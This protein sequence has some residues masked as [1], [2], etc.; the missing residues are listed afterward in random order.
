MVNTI[1]TTAKQLDVILVTPGGSG[2]QVTQIVDALRCRFD[3]VDFV[4][5]SR[6]MSAGTLLALSG[7]RI[8]MDERAALGPI[9][10]QVPTR[11]GRLV[12]AQA[13]LTL[14]T[15]IGE[16][17]QQAIANNQPIPWH[18]VALLNTMDKKE[19]G[20][21]I[22][23][24]D[25]STKIAAD[26]LERYK[27]KNW[28]KDGKTG[29]PVNDDE[30]KARAIDKAKLLASH[31]TWKAHQHAINRDVAWHTLR[32]KIEHP[33]TVD[34]FLRATRRFWALASWIFENSAAVKIMLSASYAFV[35]S[36]QKVTP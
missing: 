24:S 27:F 19:L 32:I 13:L 21:A 18:L 17:G 16:A 35:R 4:L 12:P 25:W 22:S 1:P 26:Y 34:G 31:D 28:T 6:A 11:D 5:P 20:D 15:L 9:D 7:D 30:R 29:Q 36:E 23:A 3:E 33:E 8:W 10:P 14:L 2:H